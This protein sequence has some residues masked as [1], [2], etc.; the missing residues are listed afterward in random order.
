MIS[1]VRSSTPA[2]EKGSGPLL[3]GPDK[4]VT[5]VRGSWCEGGMSAVV[6][7][8]TR[9]KFTRCLHI[10]S[11]CPVRLTDSSFWAVLD[12]WL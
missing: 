6:S 4:D 2:G 11:K 12:G 8:R 10:Q 5:A 7:A 1:F 3:T 9:G